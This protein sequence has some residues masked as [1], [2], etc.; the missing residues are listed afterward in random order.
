MTLS[1]MTAADKSLLMNK[2]AIAIDQD[3]LAKQ[4]DRGVAERGF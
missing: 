3:G 1:T 2:E 4:A